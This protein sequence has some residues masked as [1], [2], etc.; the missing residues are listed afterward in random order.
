MTIRE[1]LVPKSKSETGKNNENI[2]KVPV[3]VIKPSHGWVSLNLRELWTYRELLYFFIWRDV[4]VR[5]KQTVLGATW[6]IIVPLMNMLVFSLFFGYMARLP[7]DGI[8]YPIWNYAA[9]VPWQF[10]YNGMSN[11]ANGL[12]SSSE[13]IKKIYFPRLA[14]PFASVMAGL[15]D[16]A[17]AFT[18]L[19]VMMPIFDFYPTFNVVWLPCYLLLAFM[20]S[21][22]AG[23]WFSAM[24]VQFRDIRYAIP[25]IERLWFFITPIVY[26]TSTV[27]DKLP[28][29]FRFVYA[30]N[31]MVSVVDGFRWALLGT[32]TNPGPLLIVSTISAF[33]ILVSGAY[34]FRRMERTFADVA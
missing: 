26:S 34:Y 33:L 22:G 29:A 21:L 10:F 16:F 12:V 23:M 30:V 13:M 6:A 20:T 19:L 7:S 25:F 15:V 5:Y 11:S 2:T 32:D 8:P 1:Q 24:N 4:K 14:L 27:L 3:I 17:L 9:M 31:P 28:E 18:V